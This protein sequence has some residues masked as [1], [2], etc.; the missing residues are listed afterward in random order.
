MWTEK[1]LILCL[2]GQIIRNKLGVLSLQVVI[3]KRIF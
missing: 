1:Y 3:D 2:I